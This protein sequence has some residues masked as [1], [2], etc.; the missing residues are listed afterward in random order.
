MD[1]LSVL[2]R[3]LTEAHEQGRGSPAGCCPG[4]VSG[5]EREL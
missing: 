2:G 5:G 3:A 1:R 4:G